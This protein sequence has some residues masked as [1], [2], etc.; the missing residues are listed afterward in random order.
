MMAEVGSLGM[1]NPA[2]ALMSVSLAEGMVSVIM[3]SAALTTHY[4]THDSSALGE[5]HVAS[6]KV[7]C[8]TTITTNSVNT[9]RYDFVTS[10]NS[11]HAEI[12]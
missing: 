8:Y 3:R 6:T 1:M 10:N 7:S 9:G 2:T 5:C 11:V 4:S 12:G